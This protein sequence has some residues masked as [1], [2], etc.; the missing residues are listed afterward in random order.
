VDSIVSDRVEL[1]SMSPDFVENLLAD[2]RSEAEALGGFRLPEDWPDAHDA[3]FLNLRLRQMR[4]RPETQEWFAYAV[5]LPNGERPMIGHAGFHGPPGVNA[6]KAADAVEVGYTIFDPYRR[7][8]YATEAV[9]ALLGWATAEHGIQHF[10]ASVSPENEPSLAI[11]RRLGFQKVGRHWDDE[12]GEELEF[13]L[14]A[15]A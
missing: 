9:R 8:G 7:N 13:E 4:E 2:R 14:S 10:I 12:D 5:V 11:V 1:V 3:G 15:G 6:R